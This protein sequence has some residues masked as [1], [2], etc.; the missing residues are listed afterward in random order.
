MP[1]E[2]QLRCISIN[3]TLVPLVSVEAYEA[4][5]GHKCCDAEE[6]EDE[7]E[8]EPEESTGV[9]EDLAELVPL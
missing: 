3:A 5:L 6:K 2:P 9:E 4:H 1:V 8:H 7:S